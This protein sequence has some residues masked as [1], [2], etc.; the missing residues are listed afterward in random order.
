MA[1]NMVDTGASHIWGYPN[2]WI[3]YKQKSQSKMD[4]LGVE[5]L[6]ILIDHVPSIIHVYRIFHLSTIQQR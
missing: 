2:S 6:H 4:D 5:N 1:N 3:V